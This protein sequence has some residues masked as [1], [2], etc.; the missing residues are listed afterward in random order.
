MARIVIFFEIKCALCRVFSGTERQLRAGK[1]VQAL[2]LPV[3]SGRFSGRL[4]QLWYTE[5]EVGNHGIPCVQCSVC[6]ACCPAGAEPWLCPWGRAGPGTAVLCPCRAGDGRALDPRPER[7]PRGRHGHAGAAENTAQATQSCH[8]LK[9]SWLSNSSPV[10]P[11]SREVTTE[12]R[13]RQ[14]SRLWRN[15]W[16]FVSPHFSG[17]PPWLTEKLG[18]TGT[19]QVAIFLK[20]L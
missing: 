12:S 15:C 9:A 4:G 16:C 7:R 18:T 19:Q 10:L 6:G 14:S 17:L 20:E 11:H 8:F 13:A 3:S 5:A 2:Q 1:G